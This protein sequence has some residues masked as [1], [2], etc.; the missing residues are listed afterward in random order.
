MCTVTLSF[1]DKD[2]AA[3]EHLAALLNTG[4]FVQINR[5]EDLDIDYSD[6]MLYEDSIPLLRR[7]PTYGPL[8]GLAHGSRR[9]LVLFLF[10]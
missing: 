4:L 10:H 9:E 2:K 6:P 1:N 7:Q 5:H 8:E 3:N